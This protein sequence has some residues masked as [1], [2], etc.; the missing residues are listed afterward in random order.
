MIAK[1]TPVIDHLEPDLILEGL[2]IIYEL[3]A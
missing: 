1:G 3:N 2:R